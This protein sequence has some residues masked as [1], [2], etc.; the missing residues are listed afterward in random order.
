MVLIAN[1]SLKGFLKEKTVSQNEI[2]TQWGLRRDFSIVRGT[3]FHLYVETFLKENRKIETITPI[4]KE[5]K[6]FHQFWDRRNEFKYEIIA[7]EFIVFSDFYKIAGTVDCLVRHNRTKNFFIMDW[8]TN[9]NLRIKS[10][11][12]IKMKH[13]LEHLDECEINKY[14]LQ[15]GLYSKILSENTD[16]R[17][18]G[19]LHHSLFQRERKI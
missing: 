15:M 9:K 1:R 14:S 4:E 7:T 18:R 5:I 2:K 12:Y 6:L 11:Y 17:S 10:P 13:P 3:E 16:I 8:K 19:L